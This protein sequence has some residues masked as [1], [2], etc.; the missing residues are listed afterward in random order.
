[1]EEGQSHLNTA[2]DLLRNDYLLS[3]RERYE[4]HLKSVRIQSK[5][6]PSEGQIVHVKDKCPRGAWKIGKITEVVVSRDG[7][8]R[9]A[10][11]KLPSG[12]TINRPLNLLYPLELDIP[13]EDTSSSNADIEI[14]ERNQH[15]HELIDR[16]VNNVI[17]RPKRN[18]GIIAHE[19]LSQLLRYENNN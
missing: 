7:E 9:S 5:Q 3:L 19:K 18:A 11:L 12:I 8:R 15:E 10:K 2:W 1:M 14:A 4:K 17:T 13:G 6:I 16:H